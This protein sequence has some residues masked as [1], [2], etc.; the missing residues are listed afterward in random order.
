VGVI[1]DTSFVV[2]IER[3]SH[4]GVRGPAHVFLATH[5][6]EQYYITFTVAGE[7]AC[8]RT[9]TDYRDWQKLCRPFPALPWTAEIA[10][11]YGELYRGLQS[12]GTLIGVN[13]LWIAATAL[14]NGMDLVTGNVD[15]FSRVVGLNVI[16]FHRN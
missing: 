2:T 8:G 7:L 13:D 16:P 6:N 14:V 12:K 9:V 5:P 4:R 1:L 3:E 10:W 15:E 11:R